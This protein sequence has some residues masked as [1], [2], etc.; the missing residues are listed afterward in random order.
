MYRVSAYQE[1][2]K[3]FPLGILPCDWYLHLM[4]ANKGKIK[5]F[6]ETMSVYRRNPNGI[7]Y[8][9][10]VNYRKHVLQYCFKETKMHYLV[11]K[12]LA[13]NKRKYFCDYLFIFFLV[14]QYNLLASKNFILCKKFNKSFYKIHLLCLKYWYCIPFLIIKAG[15]IFLQRRLNKK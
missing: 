1:F 13:K 12:N 7:W 4:F 15:K 3:D 5:F 6:E 11:Y 8:D 9:A 10:A 14:Q 2:S